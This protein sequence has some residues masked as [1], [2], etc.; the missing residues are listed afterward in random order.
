MITTL[1]AGL[2]GLLY[3]GLIVYV[4]LGR[5]KYRIGL[6]DGGNP[7]L[8]RRIRIHGNFVENV[9]FALL[10]LFLIDNAQTSPMIVHL[11]GTL[12]VLG[13]LLHAWGLCCSETTSFGRMAGMT[14]TMGVIVA[15]AVILLWKF[16]VLRMIAV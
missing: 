14:L 7:A 2:L 11:L 10:L 9:P 5:Y 6:G 3:V 13:R 4:V 15:C 8:A 12:L 1:Y 16:V